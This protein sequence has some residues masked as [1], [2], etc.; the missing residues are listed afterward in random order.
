MIPELG[1]VAL[2]L[3]ICLSVAI[4]WFGLAGA[5]RGRTDWVGALGSMVTGQFVFVALAFVALTYAFLTD[6]FSVAYVA[7]NSNSLLPWY[8]KMSAVWGA[9]EGSF[10]LW[11]LVMA[12]WTLAVAR[13]AGSFRRI[14]SGACS[15]SWGC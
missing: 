13:V 4:V 2:A 7:N 14:F 10:L 1:Q 9:H 15:G 6:D 8:Y 3:S 12:G 5:A 11:V